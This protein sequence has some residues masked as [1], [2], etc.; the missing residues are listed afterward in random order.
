MTLI[1]REGSPASLV[2]PGLYGLKLLDG[3]H[4]AQHV[5]LVRGW[6]EPGARHSSHTHDVEEAV[7]FLSGHGRVDVAG[8]IHEVGPGDVVYIPPGTAHSTLN[9]GSEDLTF[10]AAFADNL[11]A[12]N[13]LQTAGM[14]RG[15]TRPGASLRHRLAWLLRRVAG[16]LVRPA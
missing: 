11:I 5:S 14:A 12:A 1:K 13:P 16:R 2:E 9:T 6:M 7:V 3:G 10:V 15:D 8:D 4:G